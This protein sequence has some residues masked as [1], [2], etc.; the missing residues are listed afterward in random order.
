VPAIGLGSV[1][2][3]YETSGSG[4][5]LLFVPGSSGDLR[6]TPTELHA[7]LA[8]T[9]TVVTYDH[10]GLGRSSD[11]GVPATTGDHADDAA[12]LLHALG[13]DRVDV[14]GLSF[15]G[16]VAQELAIR[17]PGLVRRLVLLASSS[18]GAGGA[19]H[20]LLELAGLA[21]D[22]RAERHLGLADT[23]YR[24]PDHHPA[25]DARAWAP[26]RALLR[27]VDA[28]TDA[29]GRARLAAARAAH[30]TWERL[31]AIACPTLVAGGRFDAIA[32]PAN[33]ERL[34]SAIPDSH[35]RLFEGGHLFVLQD[36]AAHPAVAD[37]LVRT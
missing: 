24:G 36:P 26:L 23:R 27:P 28:P 5:P 32:P 34:A 37:F 3:W 15:G 16:M 35:L 4:P 11:P 25:V 8:A 20:P 6:T 31:P 21:P 14:V 12:A 1:T 9:H 29:P 30:D 18:G 22:E 13:H 33:Q 7:P 19:P 17:H 2:L 10:R